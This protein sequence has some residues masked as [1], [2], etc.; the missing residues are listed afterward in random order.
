MGHR[1]LGIAL[2]HLGELVVRGLV[3]ERL[4]QDERLVKALLRLG[5][6]VTGWTV[7]ST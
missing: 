2:Q 3:P 4:L 1:E 7:P 5:V 6:Q